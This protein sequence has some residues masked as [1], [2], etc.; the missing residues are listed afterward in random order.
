MMKFDDES[1]EHRPLKE[2]L[3]ELDT[4]EP[5]PQARRLHREL[6]YYGFH[7]SFFDRYS[8]LE[9]ACLV[10]AICNLIMSILIFTSK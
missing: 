7:L 6:K 3:K 5:G 10:V 9:I 8:F 1:T 4:A 2:I